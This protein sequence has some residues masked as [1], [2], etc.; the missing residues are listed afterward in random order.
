MPASL[1]PPPLAGPRAPH[2]PG[3]VLGLHFP[4]PT[5]APRPP[6]P[7]ALPRCHVPLITNLF[8]STR[9]A[10]C[11]T[12]CSPTPPPPPTPHR[13]QGHGALPQGRTPAGAAPPRSCAWARC[14]GQGCAACV[15]SLGCPRMVPHR[16]R[17][18]WAR[19]VGQGCATR[20][21]WQLSPRHMLYVWLCTAPP[22]ISVRVRGDPVL[23]CG[24]KRW[25]QNRNVTQRW[26]QR[27][28]PI[29]C[30]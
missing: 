28:V 22:H 2:P 18:A 14:V 11:A 24:Q 21:L 3:P 19:C 27:R 15:L 30:V 9:Q 10:P 12:C 23:H 29:S 1:R 4:P 17:C 25:V 7:T 16:L 20:V 13:A 5:P 8:L 26:P 6:P